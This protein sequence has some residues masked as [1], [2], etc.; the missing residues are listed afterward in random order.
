MAWFIQLVT[1][2][3]T[4]SGVLAPLLGAGVSLAEVLPEILRV[5]GLFVGLAVG[6]ISFY[7]KYLELRSVHLK[8]DKT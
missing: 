5:M 6:C 4:M 1:K 8:K 3:P 7:I 2:H